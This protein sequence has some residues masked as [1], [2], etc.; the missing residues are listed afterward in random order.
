[1]IWLSEGHVRASPSNF[2]FGELRFGEVRRISI[3][4]TRVNKGKQRKGEA[5]TNA[6]P[7]PTLS[8]P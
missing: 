2:N 5:P 1:V 6:P 7:L 3:P 8:T 4:R